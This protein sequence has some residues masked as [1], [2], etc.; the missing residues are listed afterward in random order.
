MSNPRQHRRYTE[1]RA[2]WLAGYGGQL[3][4]CVL[5]GHAVDTSLPGTHPAGPTVEHRLPIRHIIA[6]TQSDAEALAMACDT[7]LWALAHKRCQSRQ[8]GKAAGGRKIY[9]KP[10][11]ALESSRRW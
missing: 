2:A 9:G 1:T 3:G 4:T 7:T 6:M 5:C 8:G 11:G 10:L